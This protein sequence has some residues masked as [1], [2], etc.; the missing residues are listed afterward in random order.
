MK[1]PKYFLRFFKWFCAPEFFE[2]LEGDLEESFQANLKTHGPKLA[3]KQYRKEV[4]LMIRPSVIK[5]FRGI[6][7]S[8]YSTA[9]F[10]N[11]LKVAVRNL[12]RHQ[13]FSFINIFG[14]AISMSVGLLIIA[15]VGD[16]LKFDEFH[17]KKDR[18]YRVISST[19][20]GHYSPNENATCPLPLAE[21]LK[22][23]YEAIEEIIRIKNAFSGEAEAN[24]KILP[25]SGYFADPGFLKT[26]SFELHVGSIETALSEPFS[27]IITQKTAEKVFDKKNPLGK[28][29][30]M[31][32]LGDYKITGVIQD[33]PKYSHLQFEIIGS[34][35]SVIALENQG[36]LQPSLTKWEAFWS[37]YVYILLKPN[38][39]PNFLKKPL[40]SIVEE[41][42]NVI[43]VGSVNE[44]NEIPEQ[45][46]SSV[47]VTK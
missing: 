43:S 12:K 1:P 35:A 11:Y 42:D 34:M 14:L 26:F 18:I 7:Q 38:R 9:M 16:L 47:T 13:L 41:L 24:E 40:I 36:K 37:N 31:G 44:T 46:F 10:A 19:K 17:E 4:L 15:M 27:V 32:E 2:E 25:L 21:K 39:D 20:Y 8:S 33:P 23:E 45:P 5:K 28:T 22:N 3:R 6:G 30:Q 29:I